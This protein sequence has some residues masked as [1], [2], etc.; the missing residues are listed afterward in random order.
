[1]EA[2][3]DYEPGLRTVSLREAAQ[4]LIASPGFVAKLARDGDIPACKVGRAWVFLEADLQRYLQN[5]IEAAAAIRRV[6]A[7]KPG[8]AR[9]R[10]PELA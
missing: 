7:A 5:R 8:R 2:T 6:I 1:M 3:T 10:L 9:R 4:R